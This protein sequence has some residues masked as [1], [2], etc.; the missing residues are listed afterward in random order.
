VATVATRRTE[1]EP[2]Q[3]TEI[4]LTIPLGQNITLGERAEGGDLIVLCFYKFLGVGYGILCMFAE[5]KNHVKSRL[6]GG[7]I[8][9]AD[10]LVGVWYM[11]HDELKG[12]FCCSTAGP[13]IV[14]ILHKWE[15]LSSVCLAVIYED[16]EIL[17]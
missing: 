3:D 10:R 9:W 15:P 11:A 16:A 14:D 6:Y 2:S 8:L 7:H 5:F 12:G 13:C 1:V 4:A 17:F